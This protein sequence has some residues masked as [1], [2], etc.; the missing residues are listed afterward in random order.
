MEVFKALMESEVSIIVPHV[1]DMV[2][3]FLEVGSSMSSQIA[4][5]CRLPL[6]MF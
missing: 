1:A 2:R 5:I 3:F 6:H 4:G